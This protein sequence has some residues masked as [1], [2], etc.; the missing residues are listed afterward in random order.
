MKHKLA[1]VFL[2]ALALR[3]IWIAS[4][5]NTVDH[6]G[7]EGVKE[8]AWSVVEGR[9]YAMPRDVSRYPGEEPLYSWREPGFSFFLVPVFF[10]GENYLAAKLLLALLSALTVVLLYFLTRE[11]F[12]SREVAFIAAVIAAF[13]PEMVYWTGHLTPETLTVFVF[14]LPM[15]F[16]VRSRER[17][18]FGNL[19]AA[20]F[21]LGIAALTRAQAILLAP[22][23]LVAF[24]LAGREKKRAL[25]QALVIF[26]FF[27]L[28]FTPWIIR[29][30]HIHRQLVI[31]PTVTGEVFYIANNPMALEM[32]DT[33]AGFYHDYDPVIFTGMSEVDI[34]NWYRSRAFAFIASRPGDYLRLVRNRVWRFWRFYPHR[35]A[36]VFDHL[37][38][39][40]HILVSLF[41]S[42][43]VILFFAAGVF[44]TRKKWR[45]TLIF[46]VLIILFFG[47]TVSGRAVIRYRLPIMPYVIMFSAYTV[48]KAGRFF[49][50]TARVN[51]LAHE[52]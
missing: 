31:L 43:L 32:I 10:L 42:G 18:V 24:V 20:G 4:L 52:Q 41:T 8:A 29:N 45:R 16:L 1:V 30:Y 11:V 14:I 48:Y 38:G 3:V 13:L 47:I 50:P 33:P 17:P 25:S 37:Y 46:L 34:H 39:T 36:G 2:V 26:S 23:L 51:F 27:A 5:D 22:F 9:G 28:T 12:G 35:G 40:A 19:A 15:L 7:E 44:L 49:F 6:W 21:L